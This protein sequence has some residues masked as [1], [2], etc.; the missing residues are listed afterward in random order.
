MA[1]QSG[2]L[3]LLPWKGGVSRHACRHLS[4]CLSLLSDPI[5]EMLGHL[6]PDL[7]ARS[8]EGINSLM[9]F[10]SLIVFFGGGG[11]K[12]LGRAERAKLWSQ[13]R[14]WIQ[15]PTHSYT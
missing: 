13:L 8:S 15:P 2:A 9:L 10:H 7:T 11:G 4:V 5:S 1:G 14:K 3:S 6:L 12:H